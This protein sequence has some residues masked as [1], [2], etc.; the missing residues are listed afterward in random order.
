MLNIFKKNKKCE[1]FSPIDGKSIQ[2]NEV[3]D[4][5]FAQKLMGDGVGF[6]LDGPFVCAPCDGELTMLAPTSHAFGIK[7]V[8]GAEILVH[9]GL[10]TVSLKGEGLKTLVKQGEK[11]KKGSK[12]IEVDIELLKEK[13][14]DLTTPMVVTNGGDYKMKSLL[15]DQ[16]V[17]KGESLVLTLEKK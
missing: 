9:V 11:L 3:P 8:N 15:V 6:I 16:L 12:V 10:D 7:A 17:K 2:L 1:I 13:R 4:K 14:I 5:V